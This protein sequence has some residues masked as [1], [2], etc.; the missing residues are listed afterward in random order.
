[1][2]YPSTRSLA[3]NIPIKH[4]FQLNTLSLA[5]MKYECM[6][7][8]MPIILITYNPFS[9]KWRVPKSNIQHPLKKMRAKSDTDTNIDSTI[10]TP[11][12][13]NGKIWGNFTKITNWME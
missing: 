8:Q 1:M 6:L 9:L 12:Q 10:Q 11:P 5:W 7:K 2:K 4:T 13:I 3:L